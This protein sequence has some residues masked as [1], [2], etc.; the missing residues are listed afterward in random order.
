MTGRGRRWPLHLSS[1]PGVDGD[2]WRQMTAA[3]RWAWLRGRTGEAPPDPPPSEPPFLAC[4][5]R[6][7]PCD[8]VLARRVHSHEEGLDALRLWAVTNGMQLWSDPLRSEPGCDAYLLT[9]GRRT[10]QALIRRTA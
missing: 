10:R 2:E 9:H 6:S 7:S 4:V 8:E 1:P 3:Q 5:M